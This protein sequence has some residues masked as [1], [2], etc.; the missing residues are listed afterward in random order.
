MRILSFPKKRVRSKLLTQ[1]LI[2]AGV[3]MRT[4]PQIREIGSDVYGGGEV[5]SVVIDTTER[6]SAY[7][8][9]V[10]QVFNEHNPPADLTPAQIKRQRLS[11][12]LNAD[13]EEGIFRRALVMTLSD[14][15]NDNAARIA[16]RQNLRTI[17][18]KQLADAIRANIDSLTE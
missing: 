15:Q 6:N 4:P 18:P 17:T 12:S 10:L 14:L 16:A 9:L 7:D 3:P 13:D 2:T 1:E 5:I 11:A 8:L